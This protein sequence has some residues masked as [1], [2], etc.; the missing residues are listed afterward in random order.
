MCDDGNPKQ[1]LCDNLKGW[2][3]EEGGRGAQEGGDLCVLNVDSCWC[4]VKTITI[5]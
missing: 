5:L 1:V 4:V 2:D 3:G